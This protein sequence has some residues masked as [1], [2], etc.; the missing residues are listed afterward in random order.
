MG[1]GRGTTL[2]RGQLLD[3]DPHVPDAAQT[4]NEELHRNQRGLQTCHQRLADK[5]RQAAPPPENRMI[6]RRN[7]SP[8]SSA[9]R[10][11]SRA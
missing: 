9:G 8:I 4:P 11:L 5:R 6:S 1:Q 7:S 2:P 10:R 3:S